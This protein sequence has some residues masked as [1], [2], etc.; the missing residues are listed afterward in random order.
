MSLFLLVFV[1]L[2]EVAKR[3]HLYSTLLYSIPLYIT[4]IHNIQ[5]DGQA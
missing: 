4:Y 1:E 5:G 3:R 2:T